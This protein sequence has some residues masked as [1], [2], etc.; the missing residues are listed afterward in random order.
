MTNRA[1]QT[2]RNYIEIIGGIKAIHHR[3]R[4]K[5][6]KAYIIF[7]N[8]M[9]FSGL[10]DKMEYFYDYTVSPRPMKFIK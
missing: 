7:L 5:Y 8:D 2:L 9:E 3:Y 1:K 4:L 10:Y 6:I